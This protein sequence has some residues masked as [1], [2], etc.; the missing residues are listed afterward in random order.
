MIDFYLNP[1]ELLQKRL[2]CRPFYFS[3][4]CRQ[5]AAHTHRNVT[6]CTDSARGTSWDVQMCGKMRILLGRAQPSAEIFCP[7]QPVRTE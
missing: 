2:Q 3:L 6:F 4:L 1:T 7:A 5:G